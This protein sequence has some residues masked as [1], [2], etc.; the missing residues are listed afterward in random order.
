M[1]TVHMTR[2]D[3][4][5]FV[6]LEAIYSE[7]SITRAARSLNLTQPALSHAL[8]RLRQMFGDPLFIRQGRQ[9]LPSPLT[10]SLIGPVRQSLQ[11]LSASVLGAQQFD[12]AGSQRI[13]NIAFRDVL[14]SAILPD[15][16]GRVRALAPRVQIASVR[17]GRLELELELSGGALDVALD[18]LLPLPE[19]VRRTRL[20]SD[21]SVV[22]AREDHPALAGGL[23]LDTYLAQPHVLVSSRRSGMGMEDIELAKLG[24]QRQVALRCQQYFAACQVVSRSDMLLTMPEQYAQ[25]ANRNLPNRVHPL[26]IAMPPLDIYLYWHENTEADPANAWLRGLLMEVAARPSS[27]PRQSNFDNIQT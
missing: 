23:D 9:M 20:F 21:S 4:N 19:S 11:T 5:L 6:V 2:L 16:A 14:E 15:L 10:R 13:F 24:L 26:P 3:L 12:P 17:T 22:V 1:Q 7:G 25:S 27:G 8:A 18:V